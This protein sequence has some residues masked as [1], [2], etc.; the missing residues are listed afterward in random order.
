MGVSCLLAVFCWVTGSLLGLVGRFFHGA[1]D[2]SGPANLSD[3]VKFWVLNPSN[4]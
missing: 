3:P 2:I 1:I 4:S